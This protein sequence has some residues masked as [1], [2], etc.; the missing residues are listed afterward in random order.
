MNNDSNISY[1]VCTEIAT[2]SYNTTNITMNFTIIIVTKPQVQP[3][4]YL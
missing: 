1:K 3:T 4:Y 2:C